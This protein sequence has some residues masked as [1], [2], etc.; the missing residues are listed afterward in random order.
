MPISP[1]NPS[2][3]NHPP[4]AN[5][6]WSPGIAAVFTLAAIG[7]GLALL[8]TPVPFTA[9]HLWTLG[10]FAVLQFVLMALTVPARSFNRKAR[11]FITFDLLAVTA[12]LLLFGPQLAAWAAALAACLYTLAAHCRRERP[13]LLAVR[14]LGTAS[15]YLLGT[16]AAGYAWVAVG[17]EAP[18]TQFGAPTLAR[19]IVLIAVLQ[20]TGRVLNILLFWPVAIHGTRRGP[21]IHWSAILLEFIVAWAGVAATRAF[22]TLPLHGFALYLL[23]IL[24]IAA[25]LKLAVRAGER[26]LS[27]SSELA[28]V[29]RVNQAANATRN[30]DELIETIFEECRRLMPFSA[31]IFGLHSPEDDEIDIRLRY[32][33]GVRRGPR[34]QETGGGILGWV[35]T[36]RESV[37][38]ADSRLSAHPCLADRRTAGTPA[39]SIIAAVIEAHS[40]TVGVITIQ[41][42]HPRA[43]GPHH[44]ELLE[45]FTRQIGVAIANKRLFTALQTYQKQLEKRVV[46][47][48]RELEHTN[49]SL[50]KATEQK[51]ELLRRLEAENRRDPLTGLANRRY[52]KDMLR[53]EHYRAQRFGHPLSIAVGDLDHFKYINDR[54]GHIL[55]DEVLMRIAAL[56]RNNLRA[57]DFPA[58][59]GGEEFVI[60]LPETPLEGALSMCEKL[61]SRIAGHDWEELAGGLEVTMSFGASDH[62]GNGQ[63]DIE[64]LA[65]ADAA[66]YRAKAE[67]RNLVRSPW[68]ASR[69]EA[70]SARPPGR[71]TTPPR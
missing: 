3:G 55:G 62:L 2:H 54:W 31:F 41:D 9:D 7:A 4:G 22:L 60:L 34:K 59:Y 49:T 63:R 11:G 14:A 65:D 44:L 32:D 18:V 5:R 35:M 21:P 26:E 20:F 13:L 27:R 24:V 56:L 25:L 48:T 71:N 68:G 33:A 61:R 36:K 28:A 66:L 17:G 70:V 43:F 52:L 12:L 69:S 39:I 37:L 53:Q 19:V 57:T 38:I 58:R 42:Y 1:R 67:G 64:S 29:N 10:L 40:E 47:R 6:K 23:L 50:R 16:L 46:S 15:L 8:A 30:L 45:S 51:E